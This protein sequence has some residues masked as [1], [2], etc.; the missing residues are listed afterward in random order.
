M[1]AT[2]VHHALCRKTW[3]EVRPVTDEKWALGCWVCRHS[4]HVKPGATLG[5][6]GNCTVR[7]PRKSQLIKHQLSDRH[8]RSAHQFLQL[9]GIC[10]FIA[11]HSAQRVGSAFAGLP[12]KNTT[13]AWCLYEAQREAERKVLAKAVCVSLVQDASTRGPLLLTR[14]V[15][16]GPR[17]QRSSGI[18]RIAPAGK[19]SGAQDLAKAVLGSI[20]AMATKRR[21]HGSMYK[22]KQHPRR[23]FGFARALSGMVEVFVADGAADEQL[24]GRMLQR[25]SARATLGQT[26]PNLRLVVR[27][28]PHGARRLLQRTLPKDKFISKMLAA[29]LWSKASLAKIVQFSAPHQETFKRHQIQHMGHA[30]R[31]TKNLSYAEHRF[32]SSARPLGRMVVHFEALVLTAVD[33]IR[34][35]APNNKDHKGANRA[36]DLL[37]T[38]SMLQLGMVTDACEIVVRLFA[39]LTRSVSTYPRCVATFRLSKPP[40]RT[41]SHVVGA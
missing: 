4:S 31:T 3:I 30:A 27:D 37:D 13:M 17:L 11:A 5:H 22:P 34:E 20:Q 2:S 39:S 19:H 14:Y 35:R 33:I 21:R 18:L 6:F 36:L 9:R 29:L 16:C 8:K 10:K 41:C 40:P 26:L 32:D 25:H 1:H 7:R 12:Q 15:A 28:K 24:A 38:E 23:L